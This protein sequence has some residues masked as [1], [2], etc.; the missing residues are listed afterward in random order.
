MFPRIRVIARAI[1]GGRT[2]GLGRQLVVVGGD[3]VAVAGWFS[4]RLFLK[5]I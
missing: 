3:G 2:L 4:R 5:R 1:D